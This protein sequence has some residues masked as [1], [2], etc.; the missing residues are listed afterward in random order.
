LAGEQ[1][2]R[3]FDANGQLR[4]LPAN[5]LCACVHV[6]E[7]AWPGARQELKPAS[8]DFL[9]VPAH[10]VLDKAQLRLHLPQSY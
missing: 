9:L 10:M 1:P 7:L 4:A 5:R 6:C 3:L 8:A 2:V